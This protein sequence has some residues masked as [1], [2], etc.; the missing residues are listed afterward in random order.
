MH[1]HSYTASKNN[2][3]LNFPNII[4]IWLFAFFCD[5]VIAIRCTLQTY[6]LKP[7]AWWYGYKVISLETKTSSSNVTYGAI[8][9]KLL[10]RVQILFSENF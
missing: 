8:Y 9:H 4:P 10:Y 1:F 5:N 2:G 3:N 7:L 6:F